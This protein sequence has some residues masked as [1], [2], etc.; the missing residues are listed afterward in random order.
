MSV[1]TNGRLTAKQREQGLAAARECVTQTNSERDHERD[2]KGEEKDDVQSSK[3][4]MYRVGV[5]MG[6]S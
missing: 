4:P 3:Q 2:G 5:A 6:F 1:A